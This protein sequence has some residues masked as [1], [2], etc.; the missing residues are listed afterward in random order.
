VLLRAGIAM[1][2]FRCRERGRG[3]RRGEPF[4]SESPRLGS[5]DLYPKGPPTGSRRP[6]V[7]T[8]SCRLNY[9]ACSCSISLE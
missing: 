1:A 3:R 8:K 4:G 7:S 6:E 5:T 9:A 2:L